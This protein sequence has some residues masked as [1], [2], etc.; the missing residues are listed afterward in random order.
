ME[1]GDSITVFFPLVLPKPGIHEV[2]GNGGDLGSSALISY[3]VNGSSWLPPQSMIDPTCTVLIETT[4]TTSLSRGR[5]L[6]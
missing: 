6:S 2:S 4:P 1:H 3:F 5:L